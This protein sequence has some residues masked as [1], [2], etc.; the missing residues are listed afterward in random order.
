MPAFRC[1]CAT[2]PVARL[3]KSAPNSTQMGLRRGRHRGSRFLPMDFA[4]SS[5]SDFLRSA[6]RSVGAEMT[7][8]WFFFQLGLVIAAAGAALAVSALI[9]SRIDVA[10]L[11]KD[12][13]PALQRFVRELV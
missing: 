8:P 13:R 3:W 11:G 1:S 7:S 2:A 9:R 5:I 10:A 12:W 4:L 6:A